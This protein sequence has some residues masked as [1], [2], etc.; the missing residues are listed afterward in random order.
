MSKRETAADRRAHSWQSLLERFG[1]PDSV[2]AIEVGVRGR[3]VKVPHEFQLVIIFDEPAVSSEG[4]L[5]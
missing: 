2:A 1:L 5:T 3:N 4:S